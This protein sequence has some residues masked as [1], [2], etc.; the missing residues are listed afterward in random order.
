MHRKIYSA[1]LIR[2][3]HRCLFCDFLMTLVILPYSTDNTHRLTLNY[4]TPKRWR[5]YSMPL[6]KLEIVKI[7]DVEYGNV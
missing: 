4:L 3:H 1:F 2:E 7:G 6:L 5:I